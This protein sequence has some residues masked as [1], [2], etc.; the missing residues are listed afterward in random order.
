MHGYPSSEPAIMVRDLRKSYG[1]VTAL[2]GLSLA[3]PAGSITGLLGPNGSGK[4]TTVGILSTAL[5]PDGGSAR[6]CGADVT[7]EPGAVRQ[8]TG[9]AGQYAAVDANLTGRE[10]LRLI[11][12]LSRL[13]RPLARRRADEALEQF[14]L[15]EAAGRLVRG[16]SGGMRRR[17][18]L[19]AALLHRPPVLFLDEPTTGLDPDSRAQLWQTVA[20]LAADGT[21]VLLTT[22]YLEEADALADRV[23]I[24]DHGRVTGA[25]TPADLRRQVGSAVV[26]LEFADEHAATRAA[27]RLRARGYAFSQDGAALAQASADGPATL[28]GAARALDGAD[29]PVGVDIREPSLDE[30]FLMLTGRQAGR[31]DCR[32][33]DL[34]GAVLAGA[35]PG[36]AT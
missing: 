36:G 28:V 18:D 16:Y 1:K 24:L 2:D 22:Q 25:G 17:L 23:V 33:P 35:A 10:N 32:D 31:A 11:G 6:V 14:G 15:A 27:L 34:A 3:V 30:V 12:R 20:G 19:A 21:T 7:T 5:R 26:R 13:P 8:L 4:T 29:D 9:F